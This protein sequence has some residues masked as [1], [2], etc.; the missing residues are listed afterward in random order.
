MTKT[1][2]L[3]AI[4]ERQREVWRW[5]RD[6]HAR[7]RVGCSVRDV[8]RAFGFA[9]PLGAFCHLKPLRKRGWVEWKDGRP[10][11]IIPTLESLEVCDD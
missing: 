2:D 3:G 1:I 10:N 5:V 11:T 7:E 9:S 4:T 8:C 6:Y